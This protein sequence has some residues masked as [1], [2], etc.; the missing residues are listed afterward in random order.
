MK[1]TGIRVTCLVRV[2]TDVCVYVCVCMG[3]GGGGE[4]GFRDSPWRP[5]TQEMSGGNVLKIR[6]RC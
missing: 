1:R 4:E 5:F 6:S 3:G 2:K